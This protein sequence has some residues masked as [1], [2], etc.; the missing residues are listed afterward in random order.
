MVAQMLAKV[1]KNLVDVA[2]GA[3]DGEASETGSTLVN[4]VAVSKMHSAYQS[5]LEQELGNKS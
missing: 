4:V 5:S 3:S 1:L 2:A